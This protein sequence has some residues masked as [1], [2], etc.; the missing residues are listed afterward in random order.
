MTE[1]NTTS[2]LRHANE[3]LIC[4]CQ[5]HK[6]PSIWSIIELKAGDHYAKEGMELPTLVFPLMG[7]MTVST[8]SAVGQAV[9]G[10]Q[11]FLVSASDNFYAQATTDALVL[12]CSF[13]RDVPQCNRFSFDQLQ[14]FMTPD[15]Q[16]RKEELTLL[17]IHNLLLRELEETRIALSSGLT[18]NHYQRLKKDLLFV[19]LR[20]FYNKEQLAALFAHMLSGEYND[21]KAKVMQVYPHIETALELMHELNMSA[22][23]FNRKFQKAFGYSARQWLI[24]KK[25]EKLFRDIVMTNITIT[26]LAYKYN[27]TVNYMTAFCRE[28]FGKSPTQLRSE[29]NNQ[30]EEDTI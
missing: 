10:G 6:G 17:P 22:T 1:R 23:A 24:Q 5:A 30:N 19:L 18:C 28:H 29:W 14:R 3:Q 2:H 11:M 21:F 4:G 26:E 8:A 16:R 12:S 27:F 7:D 20:S 9:S 25:K 15:T 13:D